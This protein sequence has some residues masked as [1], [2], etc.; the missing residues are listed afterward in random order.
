V[1]LE[2]VAAT[3]ESGD[4][5]AGFRYI[6]PGYLQGLRVPLL[7]G[8][9]CPALKVDM[10]GE[11]KIM[12]NRRFAEVY[13]KGQNV[14]G[15]H[16]A[17]GGYS[18]PPYVIVG[19]IGDMKEDTLAAPV[20]PYLYSCAGGGN[21]P[22]PNYLV[23]TKG[24]PRRAM[25]AIRAV[26]ANVAPGRAIFG[27]QTLDEALD[28]TLDRPR[29][30]ADLLALFALAAMTLATVGLYGL[31][32]QI[33]NSRRRE[34]GVRIAL[35]AAPG[36]IVGSVV[37]GAGR[38]IAAGIVLGAGLTVAVQPL[39][40]NLIFGVSPV[41]ATSMLYAALLLAAVSTL[42]ALVPARRAAAIDP[43]ES[44]RAE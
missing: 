7:S 8:S 37:A 12:V 21:W 24:D 27:V 1:T 38:L 5:P 26:V 17:M 42:A 33:V 19:V 23:R 11:P 31:V 18:G 9:W 28:T 3:D 6:S 34:M 40:R 4:M 32:T 44:M 20:Y 41:D 43:M 14:V 22:D 16:I 25:N 13:A 39:F 10:P 30:N 29:S 15:R 35:G 2:G 36:Q